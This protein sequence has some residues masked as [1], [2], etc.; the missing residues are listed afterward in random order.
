MKALYHPVH[1][2]AKQEDMDE[3][4]QLIKDKKRIRFFFKGEQLFELRPQIIKTFMVNRK[5]MLNK[6][7]VGFKLLAYFKDRLYK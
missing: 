1:L 3:L 4:T 2:K 7:R 6:Y 5:R